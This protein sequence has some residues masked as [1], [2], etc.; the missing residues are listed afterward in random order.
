MQTEVFITYPT[1]AGLLIN[2]LKDNKINKECLVDPEL[3]EA[4]E[5]IIKAGEEASN[6][7]Y[8]EGK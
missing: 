4:V 6:L 5:A 3:F 2:I 1:S 7:I 8:G